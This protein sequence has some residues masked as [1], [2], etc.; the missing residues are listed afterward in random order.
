MGVED[1]DVVGRGRS[2]ATQASHV[3]ILIDP[4]FLLRIPGTELMMQSRAGGFGANFGSQIS[5]N[6]LKGIGSYLQIPTFLTR[7]SHN[8]FKGFCILQDICK[9]ATFLKRTPHNSFKDSCILQDICKYATF[10]KRTSRNSFKDS[11]ILQD[12]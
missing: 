3:N 8:S 10:L 7:N 12:I 9:Y 4:V 11:C 2:A 6:S 1:D 5:L